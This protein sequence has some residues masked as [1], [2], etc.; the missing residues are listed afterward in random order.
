MTT[1]SQSVKHLLLIVETMREEYPNKRFTLDGRLVGDIGEVL[2]AEKYDLE[3]FEGLHKHHDARTS[4]GRLVQ[5]KATMQNFLTFPVD[6]IPDFFLGIKIHPD[7]TITE[8][9]NGPGGVASQ[10]IKNRKATKTNLHTVSISAFQE[11]N[12]QVNPEDRIPVRIKKGSP[13]E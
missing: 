2:A 11:L 3:L 12:T 6:H 7:G 10:A 8:V 13:I 1:I 9:F 5:I 4:D